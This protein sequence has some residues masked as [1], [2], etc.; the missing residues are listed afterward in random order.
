MKFF[1]YTIAFLAISGVQPAE[2][3][4]E[5]FARMFIALIGEQYGQATVSHMSPECEKSFNLLYSP[6]YFAVA[7][8]ETSDNQVVVSSRD[9]FRKRLKGIKDDSGIWR[10]TDVVYVPHKSNN[11]Y[12]AVTF[13]WWTEKSGV[14]VIQ[15]EIELNED[16]TCIKSVN[17]KIRR[18]Y[19]AEEVS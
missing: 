4:A 15:M 9:A 18:I 2:H 17:E 7:D 1:G 19:T 13:K 5:K 14:S 6:E 8:S 3:S 16:L 11:K 12:C 10:V